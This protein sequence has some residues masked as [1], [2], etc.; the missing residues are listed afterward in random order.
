MKDLGDII[1]SIPASRTKVPQKH[2]DPL[3]CEFRYY[4]LS[5]RLVRALKYVNQKEFQ[6]LWDKYSHV[7]GYVR[8][9]LDDD[10]NL[11]GITISTLPLVASD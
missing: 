10:G 2:G 6:D 8:C 4:E 11:V 3:E 5:K 7:C 1:E 9:E